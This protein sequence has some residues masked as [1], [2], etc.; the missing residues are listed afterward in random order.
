MDGRALYIQI[1][2]MQGLNPLHHFEPKGKM[3]QVVKGYDVP[4]SSSSSS[5]TELSSSS[6]ADSILEAR[7]SHSN[8]AS[9]TTVSNLEGNDTR[10]ENATNTGINNNNNNQD[11][12]NTSNNDNQD[13]NN[14]SENNNSNINKNNSSSNSSSSNPNDPPHINSNPKKPKNPTQKVTSV[15][16]FSSPPLHSDTTPDVWEHSLAVSE[17]SIQWVGDNKDFGDCVDVLEERGKTYP[18]LLRNFDASDGDGDGDGDDD[19]GVLKGVNEMYTEV[20][21]GYSRVVAEAV[22]RYKG[23][24]K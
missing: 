10:S 22:K 20:R 23:W 12:N 24:K 13:N 21:N 6:P 15:Q 7:N 8:S 11:N 14:T 4:S 18:V 3:L 2:K 17:V 16:T 19:G 1:W 9:N 5:S